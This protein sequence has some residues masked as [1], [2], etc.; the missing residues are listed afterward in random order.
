M[1]PAT[2]ADVRP[3]RYGRSTTIPDILAAIITGAG[4][5]AFTA[6][7]DLKIMHTGVLGT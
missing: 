5:K 4:D 3:R 2:L 6:G 1:D 7:A